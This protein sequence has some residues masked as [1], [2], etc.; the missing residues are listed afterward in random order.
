MAGQWKESIIVP[1]HKECDKTDCNNYLRISLLSTSYKFLSNILLSRLSP[2]IDKL[3]GIIS[4]GLDV[5]KEVLYNI[6]IRVWD[7]H[8]I[9]QFD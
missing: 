1:I 9:S 7:A 5:R 4:V 6:F 2:H 3:L 8:E